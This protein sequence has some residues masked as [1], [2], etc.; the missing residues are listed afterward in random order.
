MAKNEI[1]GDNI[2]TKASSKYSE[3][4]SMAFKVIYNIEYFDGMKAVKEFDCEF[5]A[6]KYY[7]Q[8]M[9]DIVAFDKAELLQE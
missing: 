6:R 9:R 4:F 1:T 7:K 2:I 5:D 8:H 3:N